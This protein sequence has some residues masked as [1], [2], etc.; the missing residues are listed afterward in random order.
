[1]CELVEFMDGISTSVTSS[2]EGFERKGKG[3]KVRSR[4]GN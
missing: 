2:G 1:M 3:R 4:R